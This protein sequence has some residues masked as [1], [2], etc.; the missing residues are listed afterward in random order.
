[1]SPAQSRTQLASEL[2]RLADWLKTCAARTR[3]SDF[4]GRSFDLDD[5]LEGISAVLCEEDIASLVTTLMTDRIGVPVPALLDRA[6]EKAYEYA[7]IREFEDQEQPLFRDLDPK[8][9]N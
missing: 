9:F 1:M 6:L 8:L 7:Q 5:E 3:A 2:D 4:K